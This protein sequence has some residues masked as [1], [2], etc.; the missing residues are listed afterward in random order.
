MGRLIVQQFVSVDGFAA[1]A[2]NQFTIF[3][4]VDG[5]SAEVDLETLRVLSSV[6]A[7][8]LGANTYRMFAAHWPTPAAEEAVLAPRINE[9]PKIVVSSRLQEAPWGDFEPATILA[10][11][12]VDAIR[13]LRT[14]L[15]GDLLVWGSLTLTEQLFE[16]DL[17]D[18]VRLI[19]LP[20]VLGTGRGVFPPTF[21]G[22][23]L[24]LERSG[25]FDSGLVVLEYAVARAAD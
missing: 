16:A 23:R 15:P 9:L 13:L 1:D 7:I 14:D 6:D 20:V 22:A 24:R 12:A 2:D 21:G 17:V 10:Q 3:D 5:T 11:N 4:D 18:V 19:L 8:V 25:T